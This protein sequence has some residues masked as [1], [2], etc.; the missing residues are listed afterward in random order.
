LADF[1]IWDF[2]DDHLENGFV[3]GKPLGHERL[4]S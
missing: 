3:E 1:W 2:S 4:S